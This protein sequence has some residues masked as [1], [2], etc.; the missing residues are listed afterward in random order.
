MRRALVIFLTSLV[1]WTLV[2]ELNHTLAGWHVDL[3]VGGLFVTYAALAL[4]LGA[5]LAAVLGAGL[6][7]DANAAVP[8]GTH[9]LLF[10]A[11]HAVLFHLRDRLP[12]DAMAGRVA[13]A[14]L[15]NFALFLLLSFLEMG[16]QPD[17]TRAWPRLGA[18]L[19]CSQLF[20]SVIG[21]WF[22]ALQGRALRLA[23]TEPVR[24]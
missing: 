10:A 12:H 16:R 6:L 21:P 19:I 23:R 4:P 13:I 24:L 2:A 1:L 8:I 20:L 14:L 22:F 7:C 9:T 15:A 17:P 3:F 5:G 11:V 18:D